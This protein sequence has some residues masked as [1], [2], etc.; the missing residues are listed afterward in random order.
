MTI[1]CQGSRRTVSYDRTIEDLEESGTRLINK[2]CRGDNC[3]HRHS[4][5]CRQPLQHIFLVC[6]SCDLVSSWWRCEWGAWKCCQCDK[7]VDGSFV[8]VWAQGD[9]PCDVVEA[10]WTGK[11]KCCRR[12]WRWLE[13]TRRA[14]GGIEESDF[15]EMANRF[16]TLQDVMEVMQDRL[17]RY[18]EAFPNTDP[19]T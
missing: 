19:S 5:C 18:A 15:N 16:G 7:A 11:K 8:R 9:D 10:C 3:T 2:L 1:C 13:G 6:A 14:D 4:I 17:K 12:R